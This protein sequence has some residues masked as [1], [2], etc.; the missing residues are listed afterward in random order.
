MGSLSPFISAMN[1]IFTK[2]KFILLTLTPLLNALDLASNVSVTGVGEFARPGENIEPA[3]IITEQAQQEIYQK[4]G[5]E[6]VN[7]GDVL[8]SREEMEKRN[9]KPVNTD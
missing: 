2:M 6:V 8:M 1:H 5:V 3:P 7:Q 4:F 9:T